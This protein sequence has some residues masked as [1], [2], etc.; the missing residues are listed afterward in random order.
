MYKKGE[1]LDINIDDCRGPR[2]VPARLMKK[3]P[4]LPQLSTQRTAMQSAK[5]NIQQQQAMASRPSS[6][7][8]NGNAT[9]SCL[10]ATKRI[11]LESSMQ[12]QHGKSSRSSAVDELAQRIDAID[13][14]VSPRPADTVLTPSSI[15]VEIFPS[16]QSSMPLEVSATTATT[17][18]E[19]A[20]IAVADADK[21]G[22]WTYQ[23]PP[24]NQRSFF[25]PEDG[26]AIT[27]EFDSGNLIQVE[28]VAPLRYNMYSCPDC[29]NSPWQTNSKQW[30]HFAVRG[31]HKG[32]T[33]HFN[34]IG[35]MPSK[36][37]NFGWTPV[38]CVLPSKQSY[39]RIS[40]R[41]NVTK[42]DAMPPTPGYPDLVYKSYPNGDDDDGPGG[43][44][45]G[46]P[47]TDA[48]GP[49]DFSR[50]GPDTVAVNVSFEYKVDADVP[51]VAASAFGP[52]SGP[53]LYFASN[54]PYS[55]QRLQKAIAQWSQ[56]A[57]DL[58][59][60]RETLCFSLD[61]LPIDMLTITDNSGKSSTLEPSFDLI[62]PI[63]VSAA[64]SPRPHVFP[65]KAYV[66][67]SSRVHPG[68]APASH[69][70][71]GAVDFLLAKGDPRAIELRRH[72]VFVVV[73]MLNPDGVVRGYSRADTCGQNLNRMY[74]NPSKQQH[75]APY[76]LRKLL[77][78]LQR[79]GRLALYIDMHA[80]A[81]KRGA[82][83][84]GNGMKAEDQIQNIAYAKLVS[85][86]TPHFDFTSCNFSEQ[87]MFAVGKN[88]EGKDTSSRV[89]IFQETGFV[90][91]YTIETS[92]VTGTTQN[93]I[94]ALPMIPG[95][96]IDV[97]PGMPSPKYNQ[98]TF[99][100]VG[101]G[102]LVSLLDL[103]GLNPCSRLPATH[104]RSA[105]GVAQWLQRSI[106]LE[107][108]EFQRR[109][110]ALKSGQSVATLTT[111]NS[112]AGLNAIEAPST[113]STRSS[114]TLP[115]I[116]IHGIA[117]LID[118]EVA[119]TAPPPPPAPTPK[120][121]G[122]RGGLVLQPH[123]NSVRT[124]GQVRTRL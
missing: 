63:P 16:P 86:N 69:I 93:A 18:T 112:L 118:K 6:S 60:F 65:K 45:L 41:V 78:S 56:Q 35:Q 66:V 34:F 89:T 119:T 15:P 108:A 37:Y 88:G 39:S 27:S 87:N 54:H 2:V 28:R 121:A 23:P 81:N 50:K 74:K 67:L 107:L 103:K 92:Y 47:A 75:P 71:Q 111:E 72:F 40:S 31:V 25:F 7:N 42:L 11:T 97:M 85:L 76:H 24:N 123:R 17:A 61:K 33:L 13:I 122:G 120:S 90:H 5:T 64:S 59:F 115:A 83:F 70:L 9:A 106:L 4:S 124:I 68:E 99:A 84:Y 26:I 30:F 32:T 58:Y 43:L 109:Q 80:H 14:A 105:K 19:P 95:E 117:A 77:L 44:P 21:C 49:E 3:T 36:M 8:G 113:F 29:G 57:E 91:S 62:E 52:M 55:F 22:G 20:C 102:L 116:T 51:L 12:Q 110:T 48:S 96:E 38:A 104:F 100:D 46:T 73:P 82:F 101:K 53:A 10:E 114:K 1:R 98:A 79:T 94:A